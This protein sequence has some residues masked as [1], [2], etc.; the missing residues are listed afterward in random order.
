MA[1]STKKHNPSTQRTLTK[2]VTNFKGAPSL[3]ASLCACLLFWSQ[4]C[5]QASLAD[6]FVWR[7]LPTVLALA[8]FGFGPSASPVGSVAVLH[9]PLPMRQK[10]TGMSD[11]KLPA[12]TATSSAQ[13]QAEGCRKLDSAVLAVRGKPFL[14]LSS[15]LASCHMWS[16]CSL[17]CETNQTG[18]VISTRDET[19]PLSLSFDSPCCLF[20]FRCVPPV[21]A[22][23]VYGP[24]GS[25]TLRKHSLDTDLTPPH[26]EAGK[27]RNK[28]SW[29]GRDCMDFAHRER[30]ISRV[31]RARPRCPHISSADMHAHTAGLCGSSSSV[32]LK[33][34]KGSHL[35]VHLIASR[36]HAKHR[37]FNGLQQRPPRLAQHIKEGLHSFGRT[38]SEHILR[39]GIS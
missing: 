1:W 28:G 26:A 10:N 32:V 38:T 8:S 20:F 18:I 21:L 34:K 37:Q 17:R 16:P 13:A 7:L 4:G 6:D 9:L 33:K 3:P 31:T 22:A 25:C 5:R 27:E 19:R 35:R 12:A 23:P 24:R 11:R 15:P 29:A 30:H 36:P 2:C 39:G 14:H